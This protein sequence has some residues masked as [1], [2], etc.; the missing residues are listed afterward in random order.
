MAPASDPRLIIAVMVDEPSA[1][2]YYGGLVAGPIF[3]KV[4]SGALRVLHVPL[5]QEETMPI[6]LVRHDS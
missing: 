6:L 1:N 5:D 3:A 4:M 2:G